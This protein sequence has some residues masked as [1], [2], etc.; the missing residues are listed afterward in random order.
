MIGSGPRPAHKY[1][2]RSGSS[3]DLRCPLAG[4]SRTVSLRATPRLGYELILVSAAATRR[5]FE[6]SFFD[7]VRVRDG[8]IIERVQQ[9]D[10]LGQMR[11]LYAKARGLV[12]LDAV[13]LRL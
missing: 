11:Q 6:A 13:F 2:H 12:G 8:L 10:M 5:S 9:A 4:P 3:V 7:Y 1:P